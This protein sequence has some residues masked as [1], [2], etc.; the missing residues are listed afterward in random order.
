[1]LGVP[2]TDKLIYENLDLLIHPMAVVRHGPSIEPALGGCHRFATP[3]AMSDEPRPFTS[4]V[5]HERK[6]VAPKQIA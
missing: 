4:S 6:T 3:V 1:M 5:G 2:T